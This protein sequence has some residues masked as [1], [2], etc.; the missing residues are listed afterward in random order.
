MMRS[1][2]KFFVLLWLTA[3]GASSKEDKVLQEAADVHNT[4]LLMVEELETTLK[5][6]TFPADSASAILAAIEVWK[7]DLVEVPGNEHHHEHEGHNHSHEPVNVT[8]EEMLQLQLELKQRIEK[9]KKRV[10]ALSK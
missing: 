2:F 1:Y 8:A 6:N 10:E 3:C 7:N 9:I 4:A 5:Q